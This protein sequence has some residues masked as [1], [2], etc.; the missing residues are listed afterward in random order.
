MES[1]RRS[2]RY[3]FVATAY[4]TDQQ[5]GS[6]ITARLGDLSLHG[7]Y[8]QMTSPLSA[9]TKITLHIGAGTSVFRAAGRVIHSHPNYGFGV[10]FD[11]EQIDSSSLAVL[12][13][14]LSEARDL[15]ASEG[16]G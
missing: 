1:L 5:T 12:E 13:A 9:G 15:Y 3:P 14:W 6:G 10:E 8:I 7:C 11:R 16:V 2:D 4:I